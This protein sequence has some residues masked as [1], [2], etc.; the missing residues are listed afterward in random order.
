MLKE[1]FRNLAAKTRR[2]TN[3]LKLNGY[4]VVEK[5]ECK[6]L[7]EKKNAKAYLQE[8][9]IFFLK[10]LPLDPK[11]A[12]FG[13]RTSPACLKYSVKEK[14]KI[15]YLDF[16]SLYPRLQKKNIF[17]VG[18]AQIYISNDECR[19]IDLKNVMG[20]VKCVAA[21]KSAVSRLTRTHRGQID[22]P[23]MLCMCKRKTT[24]MQSCRNGTLF[25]P[26]TSVEIN[27]AVEKK[28][29]I[30]EI[31]EIYDYKQGKQ[32]FGEYVNTF[33]KIKQESSGVPQD[34]LTKMG[35]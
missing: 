23:S 19:K 6:Y 10:S 30:V 13:G 14:E 15:M 18:H 34:C 22:F 35:A 9:K 3:L 32:I 5:W 16:T 28:Y 2:F 21:E 17:P 8:S 29:Q 24:S 7:N 33:L 31:F 20:L 26:W 27:K 11:D 4:K 25:V 12:L 1:S